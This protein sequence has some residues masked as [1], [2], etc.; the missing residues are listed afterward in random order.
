MLPKGGGGKVRQRGS[1]WC[2]IDFEHLVLA[3][4]RT[5]G[6]EKKKK[7]VTMLWKLPELVSRA[8]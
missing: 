8:G 1:E 3:D 6:G 2:Y 4:M 5:T 7:I